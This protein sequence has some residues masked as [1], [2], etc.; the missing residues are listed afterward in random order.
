MEC[1]T[2]RA[3]SW[4]T[5]FGVGGV[6]L[7]GC[8]CDESE[9]NR[10]TPQQKDS[11]AKVDAAEAGAPDTTSQTDAEASA[12]ARRP[13]AT[14]Q[15]ACKPA[16]WARRYGRGRGGSLFSQE[17]AYGAAVDS[18][19]N[20]VFTGRFEGSV[21]FGGG[22]IDAGVNPAM[23]VVAFDAQGRHVYGRRFGETDAGILTTPSAVGLGIAPRPSGGVV[24]SGRFSGSA[25]FGKGRLDATG[26]HGFRDAG[27]D[28]GLADAGVACFVCEPDAVV[29][30]LAADGATDWA[31]R[32]GTEAPD[33]ATAVA[34]DASG[35]VYVTGGFTTGID[36]GSGKSVASAGKLDAFVARL[37][38]TGSPV[39]VVKFGGSADDVGLAIAVGGGTVTVGGSFVGSATF[40]GTTLTAAGVNDGFLARLDTD[41]K[42][43]SARAIGASANGT[44]KGL[45]RRPTGEVVA[46]GAA[47]GYFTLAGTD[48]ASNSSEAFVLQLDAKGADQWVRAYDTRANDDA[49]AVALRSDGHVFVAGTLGFGSVDLG[50]GP[51]TSNTSDGAFLL[52]LD[53]SGEHVCSRRYSADTIGEQIGE[54]GV[55]LGAAM[56]GFAVAID[57]QGAA[58]L[59]GSLTGR[60]TIDGT[61]LTSVSQDVFI[62]KFAK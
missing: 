46:V 37:D 22:T 57:P 31:V 27:A 52:E 48:Y 26:D 35:D 6:S 47:R 5:I 14:T 32:F 24:V 50:G 61:A 58:L 44:F 2:M 34:V 49:N 8:S 7:F 3:T 16:E 13:P 41:G 36:F 56:D 9:T 45:A 28:S 43:L 38:P 29:L 59:G 20:A 10:V 33:L 42:L 53:A 21:D 25:D 30:A 54:T 17:S 11:G 55:T 18:N 4:A 12:D 23:F 60:T 62:A 40:L 1:S 19:G 39:W 15:G 51:L